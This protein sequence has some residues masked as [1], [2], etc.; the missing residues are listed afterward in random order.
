LVISQRL[1]AQRRRLVSGL[2]W[3]EDFVDQSELQLVRSFR[4]LERRTYLSRLHCNIIR[5][6]QP[7]WGVGLILLLRS[8]DLAF[9]RVRTLTADLRCLCMIRIR[10]RLA[11]SV[12]VAAVTELDGLPPTQIKPVPNKPSKTSGSAD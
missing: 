12:M 10:R 1:L 7:R 9:E 6:P 11:E 2:I 3:F 4:Q 8:D 5:Y